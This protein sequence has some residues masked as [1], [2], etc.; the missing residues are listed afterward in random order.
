MTYNI[1]Y[2]VISWYLKKKFFV[3]TSGKWF[4]QP[5]IGI[6]KNPFFVFRSER[7]HRIFSQPQ[8]PFWWLYKNK[9]QENF[10]RTV[11]RKLKVHQGTTDNFPDI[12]HEIWVQR[13]HGQNMTANKVKGIICIWLQEFF[14]ISKIAVIFEAIWTVI[15]G[16][17]GPPGWW[18]RNILIEKNFDPKNWNIWSAK[19]PH[20]HKLF[21]LGRKYLKNEKP[22]IRKHFQ[23]LF[24]KIFWCL[25]RPKFWFLSVKIFLTIKK[26]FLT[27]ID[28]K[29]ATANV[30]KMFDEKS[31]RI[32]L[33]KIWSPG[34]LGMISSQ[35]D[36]IYL[37]MR[38]R[39]IWN[40]WEKKSLNL[41]TKWQESE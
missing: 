40:H 13:W 35:F 1:V 8:T 2:L 31:K 7:F 10:R 30:V 21:K 20:F 12:R 26:F 23:N 18:L 14:G 6:W 16:L 33:I 17:T 34:E 41:V 24:I 9:F 22:K 39:F 27:V 28:E 15:Y 11:S 25:S 3:C 36:D 4:S 5:I 32:V 29:I 37:G 19:K 38:S